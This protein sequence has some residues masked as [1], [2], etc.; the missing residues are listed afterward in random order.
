M[1]PNHAPEGGGVIAQP[2]KSK[3]HK[4]DTLDLAPM[5]VN[6]VSLD[7]WLSVYPDKRVAQEL[8]EGFTYGFKSG[9]QG[10]ITPYVPKTLLSAM[11]YASIVTEK[12]EQEVLANRVAGPFSQPPFPHMRWSPLGLVDKKSDTSGVPQ[13]PMADNKHF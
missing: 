2:T 13:I 11:Q 1:A 8:H 10:K 4:L 12:L 9:Y 7:K 3:A 5:P 6:L